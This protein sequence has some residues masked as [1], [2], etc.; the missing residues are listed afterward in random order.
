MAALSLRP[1]EVVVYAS[2]SFRNLLPVGVGWRV[3]G[4]RGDA[5]ARLAEGWL[6]PGDG[7]HVLEANAMAMAP[8]LSFKVRRALFFLGF[9]FLYHKL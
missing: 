9:V 4:A 1:L 5:G 8:S 2:L 3:A 6:A 7:V